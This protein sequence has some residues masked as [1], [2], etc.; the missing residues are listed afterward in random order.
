MTGYPRFY[1]FFSFGKVS[2][3]TTLIY[4]RNIV[5]IYYIIVYSNRMSKISFFFQ[6]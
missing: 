5:Y 6:F 4:E 2:N 1:S 3:L